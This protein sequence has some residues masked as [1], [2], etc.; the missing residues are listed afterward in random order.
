MA[1][2][3]YQPLVHR[4]HC[5]CNSQVLAE[6]LIAPVAEQQHQLQLCFTPS[7]QHQ[8]HQHQFC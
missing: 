6:T 2:C 5:C 1:I 4:M 3:L 8:Q 7:E